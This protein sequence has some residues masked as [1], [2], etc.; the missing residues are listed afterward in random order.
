MLRL[1]T[2]KIA[3]RAL[4]RNT[5]RTILTML[6]II[7]GV[8]AVIAMVSIGSGAKAQVESRIAALGQNV[9]QVFSGSSRRG[10]ISMGWGSAGTLAV[11]DADAIERE[12]AGVIGVSPE[13]RSGG[14]A[15]YGN[16]NWQTSVNGVSPDYLNIRQ[17]KLQDGAMFTEADVRS[18]AKV[19]VIGQTTITKLFNDEEP[20]GKIVRIKNVPIKVVGTLAPKGMSMFGGDQDDVLF[21]PYTTVMKRL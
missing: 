4:R 17:W 18:A 1:A 21:M 15:S 6:G 7:I 9:V 13:V 3:I 10:G 19:A 5:L 16:M 12:V 14:Q 2:L 20:L 11:E 8:G